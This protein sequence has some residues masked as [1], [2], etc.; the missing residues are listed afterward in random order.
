MPTSQPNAVIPVYFV[1]GHLAVNEAQAHEILGL[2][3]G[4]TETA[5]K[6]AFYKF[7]QQ[8]DIRPLP[9]RV[10]PLKKI[11]QAVSA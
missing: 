11:E 3:D 7:C 5:K 10:F 4:R 9:G 2:N 8:H 1:P 6:K